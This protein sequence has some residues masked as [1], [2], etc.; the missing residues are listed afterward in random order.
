MDV[1]YF[2]DTIQLFIFAI[3]FV[4]FII[5]ISWLRG[6]TEYST[7][8]N[9]VGIAEY[10]MLNSCIMILITGICGSMLKKSFCTCIPDRRFDLMISLI[11]A[12]LLIPYAS[13]KTYVASF[14]YGIYYMQY[15][16]LFNSS[17]NIMQISASSGSDNY[18]TSMILS[19]TNIVLEIILVIVFGLQTDISR[20]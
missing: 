4:N 8:V 1:D 20:T 16:N 18:Y 19:W 12:V 14:G 5:D 13:C 7:N 11:S 17:Y 6:A 15:L 10:C 9:L 3:T 2:T